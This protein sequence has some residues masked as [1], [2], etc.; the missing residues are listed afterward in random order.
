M[1]TGN[2][3]ELAVAEISSSS[4][5]LHTLKA[6]IWYLLTTNN[7]QDAV[8]KAVS[9]GE[10][11]DTAGAVTGGLAALLYGFE[12]TPQHWITQLARQSDIFDLAERMYI[13]GRE[14][15]T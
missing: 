2:L 12:S 6:S 15:F 11:T 1:L 7:Y 10:D 3:G 14:K 4:Y 8:L 13:K 9:L 5:V